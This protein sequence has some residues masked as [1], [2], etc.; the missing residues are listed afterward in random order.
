MKNEKLK[1]ER[2][3]DN[4]DWREPLNLW[5]LNVDSSKTV[6]AADFKFYVHV[7]RGSPDMNGQGHVSPK[8]LVSRVHHTHFVHR[9]AT[10]W[11]WSARVTK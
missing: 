1:K 9:R 3:H 2:K 10:K 7:S 11:A 4:Q 8:F 6:K 5:A